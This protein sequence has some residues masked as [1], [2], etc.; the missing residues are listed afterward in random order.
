MAYVD[1]NPIRAAVAQTREESDY[2]SIEQRIPEQDPNI[3]ARE[4]TA[5]KTLPEDLRTAIGN[6]MPFSDQAPAD[7][8]NSIPCD[9]RDYLE[10]IDW[11]GRAIVDGKRGSIPTDLRRL[12]TATRRHPLALP[13]GARA[14]VGPTDATGPHHRPPGRATAGT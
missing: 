14:H 1:L 8:E 10:L 2:T 3:S 11:S 13:M 4:E 7:P 6:L 12:R 5:L 9:S